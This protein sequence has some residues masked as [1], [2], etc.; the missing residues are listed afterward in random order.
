MRALLA[1]LAAAAL[2][3]FGCDSVPTDG[4]DA[5]GYTWRKDGPSATAVYHYDE[6][7]YLKCAFDI[8]SKSCAVQGLGDGKCHI[9]LPPKYE[10]WQPAHEQRHCDG[11]R[12]FDPLKW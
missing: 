2:V 9:Y 6:D 12:H 8:H 4:P 7:V 1:A 3:L 5:Q 11:W 10:T